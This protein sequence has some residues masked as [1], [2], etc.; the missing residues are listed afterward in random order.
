MKK[1]LFS[2]L[3]SL[4][5]IL[6]TGAYSGAVYKVKKPEPRPTFQSKEEARL[7]DLRRGAILTD[8]GYERGGVWGKMEGVIQAPSRVVWQL[9]LET[10][11]WK[12]YGLPTLA[13][14]RAVNEAIVEKVGNSRKV[15]DFY[16][17]MGEQR[18]NPT[19]GRKSAGIWHSLTFQYYDLP[20][21]VS[22]K[23]MI[24]K[25]KNDETRSKEG[26][27]S[28]EWDKV[29]GNVKT[30]SGTLKITPFEG[31]DRRTLLEYNVLADPGTSVPRFLVRW[32][33]KST[34]PA[35][36]QAIRRQAERVYGRPPPLL[37]IQ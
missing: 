11:D 22:N 28:V 16:E 3:C 14:S 21:P 7:Y 15:S 5:L 13:D 37:K 29:A 30:M 24:V 31:D 1:I 27:Y 20:W 2:L 32:G 25:N 6:S 10:N 34:M 8:G 26:V 12:H 33:V 19:I 36:I 23:W 4:S 35:V 17:V 9:F 18:I